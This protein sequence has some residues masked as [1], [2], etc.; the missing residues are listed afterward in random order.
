MKVSELIGGDLYHFPLDLFH[1]AVCARWDHGE[2]M[3]APCSILTRRT[4]AIYRS[5]YSTD[6]AIYLGTVDLSPH[7]QGTLL[8]CRK[9]HSFLIRGKKEYVSGHDIK[10]FRCV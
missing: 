5:H 6:S 9:Y 7:K 2:K 10:H 8:G 4:G 3:T 1:T